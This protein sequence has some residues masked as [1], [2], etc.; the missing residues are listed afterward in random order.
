M[1]WLQIIHDLSI[2]LALAIAILVSV[3][4]LAKFT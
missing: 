3:Y 4:I 1:T 2:A